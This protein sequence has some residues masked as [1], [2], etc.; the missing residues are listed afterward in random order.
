[1]QASDLL[2][3]ESIKADVYNL[4]FATSTDEK[5]LFELI[6]PYSLVVMVEEGVKKGG[7]G[8]SLASLLL[9]NDININFLSLAVPNVF[10]PAAT[11]DELIHLYRLDGQ[12]IFEQVLDKWQSYRFKKVLDQVKNDTWEGKKL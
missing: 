12:G 5:N 11:R 1:M 3:R 2:A 9:E 6:E 4:R 10:P 8:E 7:T